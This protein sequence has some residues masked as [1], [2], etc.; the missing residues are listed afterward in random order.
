MSA[1][2]SEPPP[3]LPA[4]RFLSIALRFWTGGSRR[5]A[6]GL[7]AAVF[8][9]MLAQIGSQVAINA[10]NRA[11]FDGLEEKDL[12]A[13]WLAVAGFRPSSR[14]RP[15]ASPLSSCCGCCCRHAGGNG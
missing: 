4:S 15:Y 10:W 12:P 7:T 14:P 1:P 6:F 8:V 13:I 11:F 9:A 3:S 5:R 2:S